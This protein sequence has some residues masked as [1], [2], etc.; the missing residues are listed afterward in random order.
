MISYYHALNRELNMSIYTTNKIFCL[1]MMSL[2]TKKHF[3][4][5]IRIRFWQDKLYEKNHS[6]CLLPIHSQV[7]VHECIFP[8]NHNHF[9]FKCTTAVEVFNK[10]TYH[11][12]LVTEETRWIWV[13]LSY[14]RWM[15]V[16]S[17][18]LVK[19][20]ILGLVMSKLCS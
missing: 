1:K 18:I 14:S 19:S 15:F 10:M 7:D 6:T 16:G 4:V 2:T 13:N 3:V 11:T 9:I 20:C 17:W 8:T 12:K 5:F